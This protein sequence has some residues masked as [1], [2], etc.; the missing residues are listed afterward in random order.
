MNQEKFIVSRYQF[1]TPKDVEQ[2]ENECKGV[3]YLREKTKNVKPLT[4]LTVYNRILSEELFQTPIGISYMRELQQMLLESNEIDNRL[5]K[6][7]PLTPLQNVRKNNHIID[8]IKFSFSETRSA[9][10]KRLKLSV[11]FNIVLVVV[12]IVM[13]AIAN[14][15]NNVNILNYETQLINKYELWEQEL[16]QREDSLDKNMQEG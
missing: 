12:I 7:I 14:T 15:T 9:Y 6:D 5:V 11:T 2:A 8:R 1:A 13:F 4:M 3:T 10:K 16:Q